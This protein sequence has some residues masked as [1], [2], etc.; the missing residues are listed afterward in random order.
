MDKAPLMHI[1]AAIVA[2]IY[3][4]VSIVGGSIGFAKGSK[5]S[6]V[7]GGI[8]GVLLLASSYGVFRWPIWSL[9]AAIVVS[10]LLVG[11]FAPKLFSSGESDPSA[12][13]Y[14]MVIGGLLVVALSGLAMLSERNPP[15]SP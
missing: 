6:L 7:A 9:G 10:L 3:G 15:P 1:V 5:I 13:A 11:R 8:A 14:V 4:L 2:V 12:I